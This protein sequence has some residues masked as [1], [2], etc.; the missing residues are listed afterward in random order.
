M[1]AGLSSIITMSLCY[2]SPGT[3]ASRSMSADDRA[4]FDR[5]KMRVVARASAP[6]HQRHI[7]FP[8][9][10]KSSPGAH[11]PPRL[12]G[13]CCRCGRAHQV[14]KGCVW[15]SSAVPVRAQ[16]CHTGGEESSIYCTHPLCTSLRQ[17]VVWVL[18][19]ELWGKLR[20]FH[21]Q[22]VR[23]MCRVNR[24]H[25]RKYKISTR[26]LLDRLGL[27]SIDMYVARRQLGLLGEARRID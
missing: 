21:A 12:H 13:H 3:I 7:L 24:W 2:Q 15:G 4:G 26:V 9:L 18:T 8:Q 19:E 16:R 23:G 25:T 11:H 17:R 22:C 1:S 14:G 6:P 10:D 27:E 5:P 20:V